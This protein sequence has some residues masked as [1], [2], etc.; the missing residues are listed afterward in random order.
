MNSVKI[1]ALIVMS[2]AGHYYSRICLRGCG[3]QNTSQ[4]IEYHDKDHFTC[5]ARAQAYL[6]PFTLLTCWEEMGEI[7]GISLQ[8][9]WI[10]QANPLEPYRTLSDSK[11]GNFLGGQF[12]ILAHGNQRPISSEGDEG[13]MLLS[14]WW[15]TWAPANGGQI[16]TIARW[17]D[18]EL[19]RGYQTPRS[20]PYLIAPQEYIDTPSFDPVAGWE[21]DNID[22]SNWFGPC[23]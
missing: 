16:P 17:L 10:V 13:A 7:A 5:S 19:R 20:Y 8:N 6:P 21:F 12:E 14:R 18:K 2:A 23:P 22:S 11:W 9:F 1:E 15:Q 4:N 3:L